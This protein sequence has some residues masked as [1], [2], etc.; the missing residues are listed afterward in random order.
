LALALAKFLVWGGRPVLWLVASAG[1][2]KLVCLGVKQRQ[3]RLVLDL[4]LQ[5]LRL[6]QALLLLAAQHKC[7]K[8]LQGA[9]W[10]LLP[11]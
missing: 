3:Q 6:P 10:Q 7:F 4:L 5:A 2:V 1:Q 11:Q 9:K 8:M